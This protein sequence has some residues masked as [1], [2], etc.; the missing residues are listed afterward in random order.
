MDQK[1]SKYLIVE[2]ASSAVCNAVLNYASA[3]ALFHSRNHVN[4]AGK[5]GLFQDSL[6]ETFFVVWLST[7]IPLLIARHRRRAGFLPVRSDVPS[8]R[9]DNAFLRSF[10]WGVLATIAFAICNYFLLPRLFPEGAN[11]RGVLFFKTIYGTVLGAVA[12]F[13][14][15][16][17]AL[18]EASAPA[19]S[20]RKNRRSA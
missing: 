10:A 11:L 16:H 7:L 19:L 2:T 8:V 17:R 20:P 4:V 6:G 3:W 18:R 1:A 13:L 5:G 14:I 15:L 9:A 12:T